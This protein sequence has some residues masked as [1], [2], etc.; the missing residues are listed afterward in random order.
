MK[1]TL[2]A[3]SCLVLLAFAASAQAAQRYASPTGGGTECSQAKP[4]ALR[5]G[6]E[7]AKANDEVIV[8]AGTYP[9]TETLSLP[10]E[11]PGVYVHGDFGGPMPTLISAFPEFGT[12]EARETNSRLAWLELVVGGKE[13]GGISC[14]SGGRVER[15]RITNSGERGSGIYASWGCVV[16]NSVAVSTGKGGA[17]ALAGGFGEDTPPIFRNLTAIATGAE[18]RGVSAIVNDL[19]EPGVFRLSLINSIASGAASDLLAAGL[20]DG[21]V[22]TVS[23]SNF[24]TAV[25]EG[26]GKIVDAG[27]NQTAQ[28]LFVN[29]PGGDFREAAGSP[30]IDAGI[31]E[32]G[33]GS[34]DLAGNPRVLGGNVDIGAYEFLPLPPAVVAQPRVQA[35]AVSPTA[36]KPVNLGGAVIS[37]KANKKAPVATTVSYSLSAAATVTF[38]AARKVGGRKAG[39]KCVKTTKANRSKQKCT[40]L[41]PVKGS[42]THSGAGGFNKF[43]FSGRIG[44][45][46]LRPGR[47]VLNA[48]AGSSSKA[49]SF[50]IVK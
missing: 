25:A 39:K 36:F 26:A 4:C 1:T 13:A 31:V 33:L 43:R 42:F 35:L 23:H 12:V 2:V 47:Y 45:K 18:S 5:V 24:D 22:I 48:A 3:L 27:G 20:G 50:K 11:E 32:V 21:A 29:A 7:A 9:L 40:I 30:T 34:L 49:A 14:A 46:A 10:F 38:S 15:V 19:L 8:G 16:S 41:K 28:P 37:A 6:V 44:G 17:A